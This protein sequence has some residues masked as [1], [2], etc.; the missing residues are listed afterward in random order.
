MV[1]R[2]LGGGD[3]HSGVG[4]AGRALTVHM[5]AKRISGRAERGRSRTVLMRG[6]QE[7]LRN[8]SEVIMFGA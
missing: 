4:G 3:T 8:R 7:K 5:A 2:I 6:E 1:G